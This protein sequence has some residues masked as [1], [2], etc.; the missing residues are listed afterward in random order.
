MEDRDPPRLGEYQ[1]DYEMASPEEFNKSDP[2]L[3]ELF[4]NSKVISFEN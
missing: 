2:E 4:A 1:V 3:D